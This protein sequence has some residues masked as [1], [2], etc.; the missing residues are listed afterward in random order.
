MSKLKFEPRSFHSMASIL[1]TESHC[2]IDSIQLSEKKGYS[3]SL[4]QNISLGTVR[5]SSA[6]PIL[7]QKLPT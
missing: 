3:Q 7:L 2:P 6:P 5:D 1:S 4:S